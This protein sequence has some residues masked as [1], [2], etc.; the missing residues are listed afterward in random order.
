MTAGRPVARLVAPVITRVAALVLLM[1]MI[2]VAGVVASTMAVGGLTDD[3]QPAS[4]ANK[5]VL[6]DLSDMQ[7][8]VRVWARS[9]DESAQDDFRQAQTRFPGH[10]QQVEQYAA[11]DAQLDLL[12]ARQSELA[13][14]WTTQY[15]L[16][17]LGRPGGP[18]TYEPKTF[19]EGIRRFAAFRAAHTETM[20]AFDE[21]VREARDEAS[22]RLKGTILAV[23]LL[24]GLGAL[25]VSR[26]RRRLLLEIAEPLK[27][28]ELVV[29]RM[30]QP[31]KSGRAPETGPREVRA[32]AAALNDLADARERARLVES[33]IQQELRTLD[34]AKDDFVA[35]VSHELRTP[36]TTISGYLEL[37]A[38]EF[39]GRM[40]PRHEKMMEASR[41]N[42]SR[43][44]LLIDD[45]LTLSKTENRDT[46]MEQV[47]LNLLVRDVVTDVRMTA[48]RRGIHIDVSLPKHTVLV[49]GDRA[50]LH[51]ALLNLV[52]NAVKF[53][54]D[55][56]A[57]EVGLSRTGRDVVL[58]VTD[59][60][61]GIPESEIDR[62]GTRFFRASNAVTNEI[63][64]TGLGVR[65][66]QTI[67]DKHAGDMVITSEEGAGTTVV[68]R[69]HPQG[70]VEDDPAGVEAPTAAGPR[71]AGTP[72]TDP[73][74][75]SAPVPG[76]R[77]DAHLVD[78]DTSW[79][80]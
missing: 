19:R 71:S 13:D 64:G 2:A 55:E 63:A 18:G 10:M 12:V 54:H 74:P 42:V 60:G 49:L 23:L 16:P 61:I 32:I 56:G 7:A 24:A 44:R 35:N 75:T 40:Q 20:A 28:L 25:V 57:V 11:S 59:H 1:G 30:A 48:A 68:V 15:A 31:G 70:D 72:A 4:N 26:A 76:G 21:R 6:Q 80:P 29:Q 43:L 3:L 45:L 62:L 27:E 46:D 77:T 51:R 50:M 37:V 53:S 17:R 65:I 78:E 14:E 69:L 34:T 47:D 52:T 22:M 8:A 58:T 73:A 33:R 67:I 5:D 79:H 39:D 36:L 41:R 38:E 66:V 9:G